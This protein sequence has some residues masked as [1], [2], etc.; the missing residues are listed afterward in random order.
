MET[1]PV[2]VE[3]VFNCPV[4]HVWKAITQKEKMKQWYFELESFKPELGFEFQFYGGTPEKQYLH[5]CKITEIIPQKK[6]SYTWQYESDPA[7]TLVTFELFEDHNQTRLKLTHEGLDQFS[8][9]NPDLK[10]ANFVNGWEQIIGTSLKQY[11]Q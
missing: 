10:R 6:I 5:L 11:L 8:T 2:I 7:V 9:N 3:R 4:L 1:K